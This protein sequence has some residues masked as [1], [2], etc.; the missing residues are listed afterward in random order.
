MRPIRV[1]RAGSCVGYNGFAVAPMFGRLGK[2][3]SQSKPAAQV[4]RSGRQEGLNDEIP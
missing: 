2:S 4:V 3:G 1:S